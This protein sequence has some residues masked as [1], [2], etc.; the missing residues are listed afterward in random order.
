[1]TKREIAPLDEI[2]ITGIGPIVTEPAS[3]AYPGSISIEVL[4]SDDQESLVMSGPV[5]MELAAAIVK[6]LRQ[7]QSLS[8]EETAPSKKAE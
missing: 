5:A 4:T 7:E 3:S 2:H 1:M 6:H 8:G